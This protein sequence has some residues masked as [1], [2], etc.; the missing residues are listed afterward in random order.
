MKPCNGSSF[1]DDTNSKP[2]SAFQQKSSSTS[3]WVVLKLTK[4]EI[5][6]EIY[7]IWDLDIIRKR[8]AYIQWS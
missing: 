1:F 3:R 4:M 2:I 6:S 5:Y 8:F 7:L